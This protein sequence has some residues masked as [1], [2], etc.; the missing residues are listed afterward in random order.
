MLSV[1]FLYR[2]FI[3]ILSS[4]MVS[5]AIIIRSAI[6]LSVGMLSFIIL[7]VIMLSVVLIAITLSLIFTDCH[8]A[9]CPDIKWHYSE[10]RYAQYH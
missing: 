9:E 3:V 2:N 6:M 4:F 10:R 7:S 5:V 8:N 1:K